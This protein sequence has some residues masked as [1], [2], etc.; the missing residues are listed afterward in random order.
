MILSK[1]DIAVLQ[2][3]YSQNGNKFNVSD[4]GITINIDLKVEYADATPEEIALKTMLD[5]S[6]FHNN[7][8]VE[9]GNHLVCSGSY[10]AF[11][12]IPHPDKFCLS[13]SERHLIKAIV[14]AFGGTPSHNGYSWTN[15]DGKDIQDILLHINYLDCDM[16]LLMLN[17]QI[18]LK[19]KKLSSKPN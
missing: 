9:D 14:D 6:S 2:E 7:Y 8:V 19:T 1:C 17:C 15:T 12:N 3:M 11:N 4:I 16:H 18:G 13:A 5:I 10:W